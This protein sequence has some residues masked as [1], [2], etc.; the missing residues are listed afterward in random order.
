MI[1]IVALRKKVSVFGVILLRIFPAFFHIR[2]EY[3]EISLHIQSP[4]SLQCEKMREK[5][6]AENNSEY[7]H[8]LRSATIYCH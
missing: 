1:W 5:C 3:G 8:F 2:T 7:G 4:Y 6:G